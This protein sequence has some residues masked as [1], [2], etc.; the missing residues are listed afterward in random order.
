MDKDIYKGLPPILTA[1][2]VA[3]FLRVGT[4][5]AYEIIHE[6][7]FRYGRTVRCTKNQLINFVEGGGKEHEDDEDLR[8]QSY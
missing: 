2:D 7:G 8:T 4:N 6:I 1:K 5:Q 3:E